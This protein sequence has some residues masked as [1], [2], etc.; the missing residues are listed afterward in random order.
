MT[1][2]NATYD[3]ERHWTSVAENI[4][5]RE[6]GNVIASDDEPLERVKRAK[7]VE[8]FLS[9]LEVLDKSVLEVGCGPG[10]NLQ[11]L[12]ALKPRRLVGADVSQAMLDLADHDELVKIDGRTLPFADDEFDVVFSSTVL[13]HNVDSTAGPLVAQMCRVSRE[14][15]VLFEE[16]SPRR[17][18]HFS[19]VKRTVSEYTA[20]CETHGYRLASCDYLYHDILQKLC[21][22]P[23]KVLSPGVAEG[24]ARNRLSRTWE[25]TMIASFGWVD[26]VVRQP[27]GIARMVFQH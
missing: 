16:V 12:R 22:I 14:Q 13:M 15:V 9:Q 20:F 2:A 11:V 7:F 8:R 1:N 27:S 21:R 6:A 25:Q 17:R 18:E 5:K 3:P 10:G 23:R 4:A 19:Y 26:D 24:A